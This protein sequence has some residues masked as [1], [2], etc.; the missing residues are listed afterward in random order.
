MLDGLLDYYCQ[1]QL[2]LHQSHHHCRSIVSLI[3]ALPSAPS[4]AA[5]YSGSQLLIQLIPSLLS[6]LA[7]GRGAR[8]IGYYWS[9]GHLPP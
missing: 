1:H 7:S 6:S 9:L 4:N 5:G 2:I 3:P 8:T